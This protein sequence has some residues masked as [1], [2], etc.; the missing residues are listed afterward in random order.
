MPSFHGYGG[1]LLSTGRACS[2]SKKLAAICLLRTAI[3]PPKGLITIPNGSQWRGTI[4]LYCKPKLMTV[5]GTGE[6]LRQPL[7]PSR[8]IAPVTT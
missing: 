8:Q 2:H 4:R 6:R 7:L 1:P 5:C 3:N